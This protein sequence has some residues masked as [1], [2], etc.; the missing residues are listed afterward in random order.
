MI[1][2]VECLGIHLGL[3]IGLGGGGRLLWPQRQPMGGGAKGWGCGAA[4]DKNS[5]HVAHGEGMGRRTGQ[6]RTRRPR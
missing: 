4:L 2:V 3:R 1:V 5:R 6:G